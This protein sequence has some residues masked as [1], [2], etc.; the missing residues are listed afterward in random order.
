MYF[1]FKRIANKVFLFFP[2]RP[3]NKLH[4]QKKSPHTVHFVVQD[5][6]K[7]RCIAWELW[8]TVVGVFCVQWKL[9]LS[10]TKYLN[11]KEGKSVHFKLEMF[12]VQTFAYANMQ[13]TRQAQTRKSAYLCKK[14]LHGYIC[15]QTLWQIVK[16]VWKTFRQWRV[17]VS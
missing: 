3:S 5:T 16:N 2:G 8:C 9:I 4:W 12:S 17:L 10:N 15:I 14:I 13:Q 11:S 6:I 1:S 7:D